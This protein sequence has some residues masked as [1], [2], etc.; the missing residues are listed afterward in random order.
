M[1]VNWSQDQY[2]RDNVSKIERKEKI[3]ESPLHP[4]ITL[5]LSPKLTL[6]YEYDY[7]HLKTTSPF[8]HE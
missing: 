3:Q 8:C 2:T 1:Y 5:P 7:S 4:S 6:L